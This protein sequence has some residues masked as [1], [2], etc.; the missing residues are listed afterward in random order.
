[1]KISLICPARGR[2]DEEEKKIN[3]HVKVLEQR[4]N[5]VREPSRDTDQNDEI[6]LTI[7]ED[8]ER[9]DRLWSDE[10]HCWLN[11]TSEGSW[12]DIAQSRAVRLFVPSKRLVWINKEPDLGRYVEFERSI[13]L[14]NPIVIWWEPEWDWQNPKSIDSRWQ[15]AQARMV[16]YFMPEKRIALSNVDELEIT[17][18]KSYTN[19]ALATHLELTA[20]TAKTRQDL[21]DALAKVK[22]N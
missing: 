19:V 7:V 14:V 6:G 11:E 17:P 3:A 15:L 21:L 16:Q 2:T 20:D 5:E 12:F 8:H 4:G 13:R 10:E 18:I 1:M 22:S 9:K